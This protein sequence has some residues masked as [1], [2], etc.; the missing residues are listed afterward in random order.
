MP[1]KLNDTIAQFLAHA[2]AD[3]AAPLIGTSNKAG[4]PQISPK[5]TVAVFDDETLC[6]WER[7]YRSSYDAIAENP[8]V[9]VY[10]RN[11]ARG[12]EVPYRNAAIRF[13]GVARVATDEA[14][15]ERAW[16]LSP[17]AEQDRDPQRKGAAILVRVDRVEDLSGDVIMQ[18]D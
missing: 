11:P 14:D 13:R 16:N 18:R 5:G 1:I 17:K 7:S 8:K 2:F 15:R 3:G 10:Y 9:I 12:K 6:F 4:D